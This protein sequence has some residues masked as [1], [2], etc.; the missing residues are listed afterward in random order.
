MLL[1]LLPTTPA[2]TATAFA[3]NS[4]AFAVAVAATA[5][6]LRLRLLAATLFCNLF[7]YFF[8][9]PIMLLAIQVHLQK[10]GYILQTYS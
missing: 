9:Q 2:V 10:L 4:A 5:T 3:N 8:L 7:V 6:I 1:L